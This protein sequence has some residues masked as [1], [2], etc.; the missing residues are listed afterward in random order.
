LAL[1]ISKSN[2]RGLIV[3]EFLSALLVLI[4]VQTLLFSIVQAATGK[5]REGIIE[6]LLSEEPAFLGAGLILSGIALAL[7]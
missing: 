5:R 6:Q 1:L 3:L 2:L 4:G 7:C